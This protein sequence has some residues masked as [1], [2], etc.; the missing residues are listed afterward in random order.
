MPVPND[1]GLVWVRVLEDLPVVQLFSAVVWDINDLERAAFEVAVLNR[2][3]PFLKFV[4]LEDTVMAYLYVPGLPFAPLHLRAMLDLMCRTVGR[5][6]ADLAVRVGGRTA[7]ESAG[8]D[9]DGD[10][11]DPSE[12]P[13]MRTLLELDAEA[14]GSVDPELA[15]AIC[16][17]DRALVIELIGWTSEQETRQGARL[18]HLLRR[19][20]RLMVEGEAETTVPAHR[21]DPGPTNAAARSPSSKACS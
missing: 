2:D 21:S 16:E 18:T 13:A 7:S 10:E 20:L 9:E 5:I 4:L 19:A 15:A 8:A 12:H 1:G 17:Q 14:P 3:V 6:D 11:T